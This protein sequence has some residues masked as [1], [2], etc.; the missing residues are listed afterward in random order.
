MNASAPRLV[1]VYKRGHRMNKPMASEG[2]VEV[3]TA[4]DQ[5]ASPA[6]A[7]PLK[8]RPAPP[9]PEPELESGESVQDSEWPITIKLMHKPIFVPPGTEPV[10][11]LV[12]RE[13]SAGD[14][15]RAGG[16][17]CRIE[18]VE[19]SGGLATFQPIID[20]K[21]MMLLMAVLTGIPDPFL[22]KMDPRDYNSAAHR[23]RRFFLPEQGLW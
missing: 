3:E 15:V 2:F 5:L 22:Q 1:V 8:A 12:F 23:L 18:V 16:N 19:M 14:I 10:R 9:P 7:P 20:D 6:P 21:K 4:D 11:E 17:P 13:P